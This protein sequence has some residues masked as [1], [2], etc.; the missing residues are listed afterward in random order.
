M[1]WKRILLWAAA[2]IA[3]RPGGAAA[4]AGSAAEATAQEILESTGVKGGLVVHLG[5]GDGQLTAALRATPSYLVQGLDADPAK[6]AQARAH[7]RSRGLYGPVSADRWTTAPRL[8]YVDNLAALVVV[9]EDVEVPLDEV[10]RVVAPGGAACLWRDGQWRK[11]AE[12]RPQ[13]IDEWTHYLY[14]ASNNAVSGDTVVGPPRHLQWV[15]RPRWARHHDHM[16][17]LSAMVS[18]GGRLFAIFDEGPAAS[19]QMPPQ[20]RLVARDAFSGTVLWKR[21]IER[22]WPHLWPLK[23]GPA[24]LPRRL[25]A[26]GDRVY[27]TLGLNASVTALDAATGETVREYPATGAAEEILFSDGVLFVQVREEPRKLDYARV[28]DLHELNNSWGWDGEPRSLAA[29]EAETG[30]ELWRVRRPVVPMTLTADARR[31]LFHDGQRVVC[32]EGRSGEELW[33]SKP[34]P[35][36]KALRTWAAPALVVC[37]GVVLFAGAEG[38]TRHRGGQDTMTAL[39]AQSG[40]VLWSAPH[41]PSGYDSPEDLF[42]AQGLVWTAPLT[43]RRHSGQFTARALRTGHVDSQFPA[44]D[45]PHMPHHRCHRAKATER[46]ILA[47]RTGIEYVDLAARHWHRHDWVRGSCLYGILPAN[48]LTYAPQHSCACYIVAKLSGL[49]ALAPARASD[50]ARPA[51]PDQRLEKGPAYGVPAGPPG[52]AEEPGAW[53]TFRHDSARSGATASQVPPGVEPRWEAELGGRLTA[54]VVAGGVVLVASRDVHTVH[55]LDAVDGRRL[56]STTAGGRVDSPPTV[57]RGLALFGSRDGY[58]TALRA[59]DGALAW[60]FRAAPEDRRLVAWDQVESVWPVHGSVLVVDGEAHAVAG[61]SMFLDGGL[62]YLRLDPLTGEKLG[63]TVLDDRH[64]QTGKKL[65]ADIQ[66]PNLPVALPDVLSSDG[67]HVYMRSQPFDKKGR[68]T[69]VA[70]PRDFRDQTGPTAHLFCPT[71]FLDDAWWHRS[72][73]LY[74]KNPLSAAGWWYLAGWKAPAGRLLVFDEK[75]VYGF[76]RRAR[77]F[78][79]TT[80]M[81]Y[82]LFACDK[83]PELEVLVPRA[84]M[85]PRRRR[86]GAHTAPAYRWSQPLPILVRGMVLAGRTLFVAGPPDLL[87]ERESCTH[88]REPEWAARRREHAA[89]WAG[90]KGGRLIALGAADGQK[91]GETALRS[92]PVFDGLIAAGGRLYL[93]TMDGKVLCLDAR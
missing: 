76:G 66:W 22:W 61:R 34:L 49:N 47:S 27:A 57:Y 17:S 86:H 45:G 67:R 16:A 33:A 30:A 72:Y 44:D 37:D 79:A 13:T 73:W 38:M 12:P 83:A 70:P 15:G 3:A 19:M 50:P 46:Y 89:A 5:C 36:W 84:K 18:A 75:S 78:P 54:P 43:N 25:V 90:E 24:Q 88:L 7:I 71:G 14:D 10:M 68:R 82:H 26:A 6:V 81:E 60:Q 91:L 11:R 40:E 77:H 39:S 48:G 93:A 2:I 87:D 63:E 23:S 74:G 42:V 1:R 58:V 85:H 9:A 31:V 32:L 62:R 29:I 59:S 41:P 4:L 8:P 35:R 28:H 53:P 55:A 92:P 52:Q 64:P 80:W 56:W 20:W 65:D 69:Q 21:D 51:A